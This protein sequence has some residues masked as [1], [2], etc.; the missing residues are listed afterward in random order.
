MP[1]RI[2][3][4]AGGT[5]YADIR[6]GEGHT[7]HEVLF[8]VSGL[9]DIDSN[10][11]LPVGFPI[12]ATGLPVTAGTAY[13]YVGPEPVYV[14]STASADVFGNVI[15]SGGLNRD[16]IEDN[17]GRVLTAAEIAG[18]PTTVSML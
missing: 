2:T 6:V 12:L 16:M 9:T 1:M 11:Y 10:G 13:G 3:T 18:K 7:I 14:V 5:G 4:T 17:L 8:D 15:M